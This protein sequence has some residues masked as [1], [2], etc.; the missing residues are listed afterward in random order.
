MWR[1]RA[2]SVNDSCGSSATAAMPIVPVRPSRMP[3]APGTNPR[4]LG[5]AGRLRKVCW[6]NGGLASDSRDLP[7]MPDK[8]SAAA[9]LLLF[10]KPCNVVCQFSPAGARPVLAHFIPVPAVYPAG[11]L[12]HD[13]EGLVLLTNDGVLQARLSDPRHGTTKRYWAQVEGLPDAA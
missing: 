11:R 9:R 3:V 2:A 8:A 13:S 7:I 6:F 12:D 1:C 4:R 5:L 10:N